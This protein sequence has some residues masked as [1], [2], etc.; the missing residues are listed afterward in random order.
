MKLLELVLLPIMQ[1][2]I[3]SLMVLPKRFA[4]YLANG[5]ILLLRVAM[6]RSTSVALRNLEMMFPQME[7]AERKA[8][9]KES[10]AT[11][12]GNLWYYAHIPKIKERGPEHYTDFTWLQEELRRIRAEHSDTGILFCTAHMNYFEGCVQICSLAGERTVG[13]LAR[14]FGLPRIDAWWDAR[15]MLYNC[16]IYGRKGGFKETIERLNAGQ[17]VCILF[18]QNVKR[19]HAVF[20]DFF[21]IPAAT[22]KTIALASIRTGAPVYLLT[23]YHDQEKDFKIFLR[24]IPPASN[25]GSD[26]DK[27]IIGITAAAHR[28]LE[29]VVSLY[30]GQWFLIHRRFKTRPAGEEEN[31]YKT[32]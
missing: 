3:W 30:P 21:G 31:L 10:F 23:S 16:E 11:L 6:W 19:N 25:F 5:C 9:V 20:V 29:E 22:T 26:L 2:I 18:D 32:R 14:G 7:H 28:A 1:A 8:V 4:M 27:Q 15:R 17:D 24:K 12:A 13:V